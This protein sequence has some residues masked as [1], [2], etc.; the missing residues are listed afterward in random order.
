[1]WIHDSDSLRK[2]SVLE[3]HNML[4]FQF[5]KNTKYKKK[6]ISL[7]AETELHWEEAEGN[8]RI[9]VNYHS[10]HGAIKCSLYVIATKSF[11]II[12]MNL[13]QI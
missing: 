12:V 10:A 5:S 9:R 2:Q 4:F 1:M 11:S 13:L 8:L 7:T 3:Y 6:I